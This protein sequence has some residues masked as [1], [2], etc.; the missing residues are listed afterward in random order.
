MLKTVT[1][2]DVARAAGVSKATVSNVFSQPDRV[3]PE[4]RARVEEVAQQIGYSGPDVK[5]RLLSSGKV[6]A[7]GVF[8]PS[9]ANFAWVFDTPFMCAFLGGVAQVCD[10]NDAGLLLVSTRNQAGIWN[11]H[12]AVADGFILSTLEQAEYLNS[13]LRKKIPFVLFGAAGDGQISSVQFDERGGARLLARHLIALGHRKFAIASM[14]RKDGPPIVH[15]PD[16]TE[17]QL[18]AAWQS[19]R[20][21]MAG[22]AEALSEAGLSIGDQPIVEACGLETERLAYK[23]GGA[24][25]LLDIAEDATAIIALSDELTTSILAEAKRR[26]IRVPADISLAGFAV[27]SNATASQPPLTAV[28]KPVVAAG[29]EAAKILF[30]GGAARNVICPLELK[31]RGSTAPQLRPVVV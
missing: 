28:S 9:E 7:I 10:E 18:L 19:D 23:G 5:G 4:M 30:Q 17:P 25:A 21:A 6:N 15:R 16:G 12:N 27:E 26:G 29:R 2:Q 1:L 22:I 3:R 31:V 8:P 13:A 20:D 11:I 14:S 24:G